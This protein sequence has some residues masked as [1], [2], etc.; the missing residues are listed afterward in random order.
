MSQKYTPLSSPKGQ[1]PAGPR[2]GSDLRL[3]TQFCRL[4]DHS[5]LAS[6]ICPLADEAGLAAR[7]AFLVGRAGACPLVSG[8]W[9]WPSSG[10]GHV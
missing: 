7:A 3:W 6:G 5:F 10:Q 1:G 8:A 9:S 2:V 4:Q